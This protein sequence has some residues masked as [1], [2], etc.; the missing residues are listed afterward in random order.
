[1]PDISTKPGSRWES[2]ETIVQRPQRL[3]AVCSCGSTRT[4]PTSHFKRGYMSMMC[5]RCLEIRERERLTR[6]F[7][8]KKTN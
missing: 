7:A 5:R 6:M 3:H 2:D 8:S 4:I 1:M